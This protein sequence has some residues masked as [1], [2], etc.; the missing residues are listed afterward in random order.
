MMKL[1]SNELQ[2]GAVREGSNVDDDES[3]CDSEQNKDPT[4][5]QVDELL[6]LTNEVMAHYEESM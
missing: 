3:S 5:G 6:K 2:M 1:M 4:Q